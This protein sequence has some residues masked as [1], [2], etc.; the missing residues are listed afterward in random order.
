MVFRSLVAGL[1]LSVANSSLSLCLAVVVVVVHRTMVL[2]LKPYVLSA[3][4]LVVEALMRAA[5][6]IVLLALA[7]KGGILGKGERYAFASGVL[8]ANLVVFVSAYRAFQCI[9]QIVAAR[10]GHC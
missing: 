7:V 8:C 9:N 5:L 4:T 3:I 2:Q 10:L 6:S 1:A